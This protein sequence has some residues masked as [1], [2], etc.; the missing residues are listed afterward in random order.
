VKKKP[1]PYRIAIMQAGP[2]A[3]AVKGDVVVKSSHYPVIDAAKALLAQGVD[4]AAKLVVDCG[5]SVVPQSIGRL[6]RATI[7][8]ISISAAR[9]APQ[10]RESDAAAALARYLQ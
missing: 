6:A 3:Y 4:P 8:P 10:T 7:H 2:G 1:Q 9:R 5:V